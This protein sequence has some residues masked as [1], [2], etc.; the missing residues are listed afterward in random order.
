[1]PKGFVDDMLRYAEDR[2]GSYIN[3]DANLGTVL[4]EHGML[5]GEED[6]SAA[7]IKLFAANGA[8]FSEPLYFGDNPVRKALFFNVPPGLYE[9]LVESNKGEWL[10][11]NTVMVYGETL[12]YLRTGSPTVQEQQQ[13][14]SG[15]H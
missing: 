10:A 6:P 7:R 14:Q 4:V 8:E 3:Q 2:D 13:H 12:S 1:V 11:V 5:V 9:V 15:S